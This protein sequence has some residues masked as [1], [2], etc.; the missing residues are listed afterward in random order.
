MGG[1]W[2]GIRARLA[3]HIALI[4]AVAFLGTA[5]FRL[6]IPAVSFYARTYLEA[7]AFSIG[8]L[9]SA[10]FGARALSAIASGFLAERVGLKWVIAPAAF[11]LNALAVQAYGL[12][13]S[14]E[15]FAV[16][17]L[18]QG[19]LNGFAWIS[20]QYALGSAAPLRVRGRAYAIYFALGSLGGVFG[21][22]TYSTLASKP[23]TYSLTASSILFLSASAAS[24]LLPLTFKGVEPPSGREG[25][26]GGGRLSG[27]LVIIPVIAMMLC[28]SLYGSVV[29]GDLIYIYV[30][31]FLHISKS[32]VAD[33]IAA[34]GAA[35]LICSYIISWVSDRFSD[36][37]ALR[38][39]A[40]LALTGALLVSVGMLPALIA[41]LSINLVGS[42]AIVTVSRKVAVSRCGR[43]GVALGLINASGNIGS[44]TGSAIGGRI[45]DSLSRHSVIIGGVNLSTFMLVMLTPLIASLI[46]SVYSSSFRGLGNHHN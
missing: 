39:S 1:G 24:A 21:N 4:Y 11:A 36:E 12:V 8:L 2:G 28:V 44:V 46:I 16:I 38:F 41:G 45:Y 30:K 19:A 17:R 37:L 15:W 29:R 42:S 13:H 25:V 26:K 32:V 35:S 5:A 34:S 10:F 23:L 31:E 3:A 27:V 22:L 20:I 9:T 40:I 33:A 7:S 6:S 43:G 14:V 18:T